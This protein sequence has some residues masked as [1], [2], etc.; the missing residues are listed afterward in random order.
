MASMRGG[1]LYDS[2]FAQRMK[3]TGIHAKQIANTFKVYK[4][5]YRLDTPRAPLSTE[6]FR[7]P[8]ESGDQMPLL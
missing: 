7:V 1:K 6:H 3:G 4:Q 2:D 8:Q 5:K